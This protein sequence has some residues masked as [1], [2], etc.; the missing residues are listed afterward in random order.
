MF[1]F[2]KSTNFIT[3]INSVP[4]QNAIAMLERDRDRVFANTTKPGG[5]VVLV[6]KSMARSQRSL[7]HFGGENSI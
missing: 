5:S 2:N 3:E 4:V 1:T 7:K 6:Q